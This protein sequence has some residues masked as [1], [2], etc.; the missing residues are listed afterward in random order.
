MK[1][2]LTA[3]LLIPIFLYLILWAPYWGFLAAVAVVSV[4]CYREY[5]NLAALH[6]I[7]KPGLF[8]YA[9]GLL[10]LFL[11]G[12]EEG[13]LVLVAILAMALALRV[14]D[15]TEWLPGA[16]ALVLG[17][18]YVFGSLRCGV[19]LRAISPYWLLFA[20]SLNWAG[21]IAALYTGK[22]MGR[23]KLAPHVS[24]AK[25]WEGAVGSVAVSLVYGAVYIPRFMPS[26]PLAEA[27]TL[28]AVANI[29]GQ[30]GD[31]CESA[32]K[33]G[34]GVKDSGSL[35]PGHGGWLDRVDSSLFALPVVYYVVK[36][37]HW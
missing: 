21:D 18:L 15:L 4:L 2:V 9:A 5:A 16:A 1:R 25:T 28:T 35:L 29:A 32:M 30:L 26:A 13:F 17:V 19:E 33:R 36:N 34:A 10:V 20:L 24:P 37:L 22:L 12:T 11:P 7:A 6:Q 23:H 31:L 3:L 14:Q 8:G 27:L